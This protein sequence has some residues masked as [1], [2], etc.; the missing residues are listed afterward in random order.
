MSHKSGPFPSSW[1][2]FEQIEQEWTGTTTAE[3]K[4]RDE[5]ECDNI[6]SYQHVFENNVDTVYGHE[7][8]RQTQ[9]RSD[10]TNINNN[11]LQRGENSKISE[12]Q[13]SK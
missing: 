2:H 11:D 12:E 1:K 10:H 4:N 5:I 8:Y 3:K 6:Y 9:H 7:D 13:R